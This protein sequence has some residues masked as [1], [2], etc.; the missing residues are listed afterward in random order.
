MGRLHM[1]SATLVLI[2]LSLFLKRSRSTSAFTKGLLFA[3]MVTYLI[4]VEVLLWSWFDSERITPTQLCAIAII[5]LMV[6]FVQR[7]ISKRSETRTV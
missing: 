2:P 5:L 3:G 4:P 6:G 1:T 7:D